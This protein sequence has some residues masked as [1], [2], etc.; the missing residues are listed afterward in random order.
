MGVSLSSVEYSQ[1]INHLIRGQ[2]W[3]DVVP[4]R[5]HLQP[6][7]ELPGLGRSTMRSIDEGSF[8]DDGDEGPTAR[9]K[10][11]AMSL[12]D[13]YSKSSFGVAGDGTSPAGRCVRARARARADPHLPAWLEPAQRPRARSRAHP[14]VSPHPPLPPTHPP[15]P[16]PPP[17]HAA[18]RRR[19][20]SPL[21]RRSVKRRGAGP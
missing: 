13:T 11:P 17:N 4:L 5:R 6:K 2:L 7:P 15:T 20:F 12:D 3:G 16:L 1:P 9:H 21:P 19:N 8:S 14:S 18:R 10:A